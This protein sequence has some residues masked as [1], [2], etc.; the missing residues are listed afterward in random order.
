MRETSD[1]LPAEIQDQLN[2]EER[3][4]IIV[5]R[6]RA[7]KGFMQR[8]REAYQAKLRG[9]GVPL[10]QVQREARERQNRMDA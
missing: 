2:R 8:L 5:A 4:R 9:E 7:D 3:A 6:F 10:E 1:K